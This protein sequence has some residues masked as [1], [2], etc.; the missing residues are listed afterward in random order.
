[1][2]Y[3]LGGWT[4]VCLFVLSKCFKQMGR[5][6]QIFVVMGNS[7]VLPNEILT[8]FFFFPDFFNGGGSSQD[9]ILG[10]HSFLLHLNSQRTQKAIPALW[11]VLSLGQGQHGAEPGG[12]GHSPVSQRHWQVPKTCLQEHCAQQHLEDGRSVEE[13]G[14]PLG[15]CLARC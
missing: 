5:R 13:G 7:F 11:P 3:A 15:F 12:H 8:V 2:V 10:S 14:E 1:M 9:T 4:F 6:M